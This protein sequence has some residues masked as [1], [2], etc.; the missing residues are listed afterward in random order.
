MNSAAYC[1]LR[2]FTSYILASEKPAGDA[3][4]ASAV[5]TVYA[6]LAK[7]NANSFLY[8]SAAILRTTL[9]ALIPQ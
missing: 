4:I 2:D 1:S 9:N 8:A 5:S 6:W 3:L 7:V